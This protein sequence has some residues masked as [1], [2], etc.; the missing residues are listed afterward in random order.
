LYRG[1]ESARSLIIRTRISA[2]LPRLKKART[3]A[4]ETKAL[5]VR[6][7][8]RG[9]VAI[10]RGTP[11]PLLQEYRGGG[12]QEGDTKVLKKTRFCIN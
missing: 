12:A 8:K 1:G 6:G 3:A 5:K 2:I 10:W 4:K 11:R 9:F 7:G